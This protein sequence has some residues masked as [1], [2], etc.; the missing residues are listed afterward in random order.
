MPKYVL[1]TTVGAYSA[2]T[3]VDILDADQ[4]EK[5]AIVRARRRNP[6]D[7]RLTITDEFAVEW[8]QLTKRRERTKQW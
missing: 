1:N 4:H 6:S 2:G 8:D 7:G 5:T 3:E